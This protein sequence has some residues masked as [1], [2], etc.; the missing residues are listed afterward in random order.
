MSV[1]YSKVPVGNA[2]KRNVTFML[3]SC[4]IQG[5]LNGS[6]ER[7]MLHAPKIVPETLLSR[8][9]NLPMETE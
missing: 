9:S 6:F 3:H 8:I 5:H 2:A 7:K 4:Y 1:S